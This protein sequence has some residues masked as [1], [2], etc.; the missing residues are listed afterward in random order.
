[1]D[2]AGGTEG[3]LTGLGSSACGAKQIC[4]IDSAHTDSCLRRAP[5]RDGPMDGDAFRAYVKKVLVAG[6]AP[7]DAIAGRTPVGGVAWRKQAERAARFP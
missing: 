5:Y 4:Q 6:L 3:E 7:G 1:M 2:A